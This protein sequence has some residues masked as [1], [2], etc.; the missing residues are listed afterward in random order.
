MNMENSV[1]RL[2]LERYNRGKVSSGERKCIEAALESDTQLRLLYEEL[3]KSDGEIRLL[4]PLENLPQLAAIKDTVV[5]IPIDESSSRARFR[6]VWYRAKKVKWGLAAAAVLVCVLFSVFYFMRW[7]SS[8]IMLTDASSPYIGRR[9][10]PSEPAYEKELFDGELTLRPRTPGLAYDDSEIV[11]SLLRA[12]SPSADSWSG[13]GFN[14]DMEGQEPPAFRD[15]SDLFA[16]MIQEMT[17]E[18]FNTSEFDRIVDNPFMR[19]IDNPLS[20]FSVDVDTAGY[21]ITRYNLMNGRMPPKSA[22]RM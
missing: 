10:A 1:S 21:S 5:P 15:M 3:K 18:N 19:V 9:P 22:V 11:G 20:T 2:S 6:L 16:K 14:P 17:Q 8:N 12:R 4:Y 7:R 13:T